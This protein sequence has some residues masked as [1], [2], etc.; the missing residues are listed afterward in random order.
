MSVNFQIKRFTLLNNFIGKTKINKNNNNKN[1]VESMKSYHE[2]LQPVILMGNI[3]SIF[4]IAGIFTSD[5]TKLKFYLHY[6]VTIYAIIVLFA[7]TLEL[8]FLMMFHYR[9]GFQFFMV[10]EWNQI[11]TKEINFNN[12][13]FIF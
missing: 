4:P 2:I 3:F 8:I 10:G 9:A 1:I 6:P 12:I 5:S 7:F 11:F 13:F